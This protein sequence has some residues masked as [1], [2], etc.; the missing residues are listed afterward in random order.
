MANIKN[1]DNASYES[2]LKQASQKKNVIFSFSKTYPAYLILAAF[3]VLSYFVWDFFN[4]KV[5]EDRNIAFEKA[6]G[7]VMTRF[8]NKN[9]SNQQI[10]NSITGIY[11]QERDVVKQYF[12]LYSSVP[13]RNYP[14]IISMM[15]VPRVTKE[16]KEDFIFNCERQKMIGYN[17]WPE[18]DRDYYY[19]VYYVENYDTN[20]YVTGY[21]LASEQMTLTAIEK[22]RDDNAFTRTPIFEIRKDQ[23]IEI[24]I[25]HVSYDT[26][27]YPWGEIEIQERTDYEKK[28]IHQPQRNGFYLMRAVFEKG[29]ARETIDERKANFKGVVLIELDSK[30][31]FEKALGDGQPGDTTIVFDIVEQDESNENSI[32]TS[33]NYESAKDNNPVV[34]SNRIFKIA[35]KEF[36][37]KFSTVKNFGDPLQ[38]MLPTLALAI[39]LALS[40]VFFGFVLSVSTGKARAQDLADRMT[41]SQRRIVDSSEDIIAVLGMDGAW[42]SMNP[43]SEAILSYTPSELTG[44]KL[45]SLILEEE[46]LARFKNIIKSGQ[47]EYTERTD[48]RM[49]GKN[50][51]IKWLSWSFTISNADQLIYCI[52][53]DVTLE[54][55]AE[56]EARLRSKQIELAEQFNRE[57]SEF[58]S[59]FM[60][61]LS[62]QMRNSLTGILGYIQLLV[63]EI[64][65][66]DEERD[67]YLKMAEES[68]EEMFTFVADMLDVATETQIDITTIQLDKIMKNIDDILNKELEDGKSISITKMEG[69]QSATAVGDNKL[70]EKAFF[71][72]FG[73]LSKGVDKSDIQIA[74]TEN[75]Y[76]GAT[77]IQIMTNG[78][79]LVADMIEVFKNNKDNLIEALKDDQKDVVLELAIAASTFRLMNGTMA[80]D[81]FGP[82]EGNV[83]QITMPLN[84]PIDK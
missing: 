9:I 16:G 19:P 33:S 58:K 82:E 68:S 1:M 80:L 47:N 6:V 63:N 24:R 74:S 29:S 60:S 64:Y 5:A 3:L 81:T 79:L 21:D 41:R 27:R 18:A 72:L 62:H 23:D 53:R 31:M 42:K 2:I 54:K 49:K 55:K 26:I 39:S 76:E 57:A 44:N 34:S 75:T 8:E 61:K 22:A 52:G 25:P 17:I 37:I 35:D 84:K 30:V 45:E 40:L 7:S 28:T 48:F 83:V 43:A 38:A 14:S 36:I 59:F 65:D 66:D 51:E 32:F 12:E 69:S 4:N 13:T 20:L 56:E 11:D 46:D 78:N 70:L 67:S 77:E 50:D 73:A 10:L 71:H 15:Y